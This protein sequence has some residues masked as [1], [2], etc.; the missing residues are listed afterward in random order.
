MEGLIAFNL[1]SPHVPL[2]VQGK[3]DDIVKDKIS[4]RLR[5]SPEFLPVSMS[6]NLILQVNSLVLGVSYNQAE[7]EEEV[8][9]VT[10]R[11]LDVI[12]FFLGPVLNDEIIQRNPRL[13]SNLFTTFQQQSISLL[14]KMSNGELIHL[15]RQGLSRENFVCRP[16]E[17]L[18]KISV[19]EKLIYLHTASEKRCVIFGSIDVVNPLANDLVMEVG[20]LKHQII[21]ANYVT[22]NE[23]IS[24]ELGYYTLCC[25]QSEEPP[26]TIDYTDSVIS[27]IWK[28]TAIHDETMVENLKV[29]IRSTD[30][31]C[32]T[33]E[34]DPPNIS[35]RKTI[36]RANN[37]VIWEF[38]HI[39]PSTL[40]SLSYTGFKVECIEVEF[41]L[42]NTLISGQLLNDIRVY[43]KSTNISADH[44]LSI[45]KAS[46]SIMTKYIN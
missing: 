22:W 14:L 16:F 3:L 6:N 34:R 17:Q 1:Q 24:L 2:L 4:I 21:P 26:F 25:Y 31:Y 32:P 45:I 27:L 44:Q 15:V 7:G 9:L 11:F 38:N 43:Q 35:H 41:S 40:Y 29:Y 13:V 33:I 30:E 39:L 12:R 42:Q 20:Q 37:R 28:S 23:M 36:D 46:T 18:L 8:R 5:H 19:T 10:K